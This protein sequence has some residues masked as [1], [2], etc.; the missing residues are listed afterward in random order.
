MAFYGSLSRAQ[1]GVLGRGQTLTFGQLTHEQKSRAERAVFGGD[2]RY[3]L[4]ITYAEGSGGWG[5]IDPTDQLPNGLPP[6]A[7]I[8]GTRHVDT[9]IS[10]IDKTDGGYSQFW[11]VSV[12]DK[13][14]EFWSG[15]GPRA[16]AGGKSVTEYAV[17][18]ND[19]VE[20]RIELQPGHAVGIDITSRLAR[21]QVPTVKFA[22]LPKSAQDAVEKGWET[23]K[24]FGGIGRG[25]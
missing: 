2:S 8:V 19:R 18:Y 14:F 22:E 20:L 13:S 9:S 25:D 16:P 6:R 15:P 10:F 12:P 1:R 7:K 3:N 17:R 5:Y 11:S 24:S 4:R 21:K 23:L